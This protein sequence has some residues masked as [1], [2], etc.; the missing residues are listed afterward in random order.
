MFVACL[1]AV[2]Y[3]AV[4]VFPINEGRPGT[5][6][7]QDYL[8]QGYIFAAAVLVG[9]TF[10]PDFMALVKGNIQTWINLFFALACLAWLGDR[11]FL[12]GV[13]I[14]LAAA[15]KPQLAAL[16]LWALLWR[17]WSFSA[18]FISIGIPVA[19]LS[20]FA[21]KPL[22][23]TFPIWTRWQRSPAEAKASF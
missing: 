6:D 23:T 20:V 15:I 19:I 8:S 22:T 13:L 12:A 17:Q 2:G 5:T 7:R 14:A 1:A 10:Y 4:R 16:L 3:L 9:L 18:G 21:S 11:K